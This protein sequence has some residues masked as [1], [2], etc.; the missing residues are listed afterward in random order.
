MRQVGNFN[1]RIFCA[2]G[3][4]IRNNLMIM[5]YTSMLPFGRGGYVRL[6]C[7][8]GGLGGKYGNALLLEVIV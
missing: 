5:F 4:V 8:N 7:L 1:K 3:G 6:A 2:N